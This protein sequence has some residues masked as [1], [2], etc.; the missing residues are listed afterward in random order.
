MHIFEHLVTKLERSQ[1]SNTIHQT[2]LMT[3]IFAFYRFWITIA[4]S[5]G[6]EVGKLVEALC[7]KQEGSGFDSR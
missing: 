6:H 4:G 1:L 5:L 2:L 3:D 7:Y